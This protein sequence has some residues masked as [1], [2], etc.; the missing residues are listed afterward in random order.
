MMSAWLFSSQWQDGTT[1]WRN[2]NGSKIALVSVTGKITVKE[3][4]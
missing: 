3:I 4:Q 2:R 1:V